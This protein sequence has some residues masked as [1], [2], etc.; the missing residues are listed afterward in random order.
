MEIRI[1][2]RSSRGFTLVELLVV[3]AI[4]GILIALLLPAIQA[5]RE[6]ARRMT[7]Q[8]NL[9]Q[10]GLGIISY[11]NTRKEYPPP[12]VPDNAPFPPYA[13]HSL[14]P[15]IAPYIE[16]A[17]L[18]KN[19]DMKQHWNSTKNLPFSQQD[20][21]IFLCP[22]APSVP[23]GGGAGGKSLTDYGPCTDL[24][25]SSVMSTLTSIG[26]LKRPRKDGGLTWA[27]GFFHIQNNYDSSYQC[28]KCKQ[29]GCPKRVTA[30]NIQDGI[31]HTMMWFEDGGRPYSYTGKTLDSGSSVSG[32]RWADN[33]NWWI[34]HN[35]CANGYQ[36]FNCNNNNEIY[37]FHS[38]G[39]NFLYGDGS[40]RFHVNTIDAETFVSLF[41]RAAGDAIEDSSAL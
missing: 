36:V 3:I 19:Y 17:H 16:I 11:E 4:I 27:V 21:G 2:N 41:T 9:R 28:P 26:A 34:E 7:C 5:T 40:V 20:I 13:K 6:T 23:R 14:Y 18:L 33:A 24:H 38:G 10:I 30:K 32:G 29:G 31:S 1:R 35:T 37:S 25:T 8:S 22:T 12:Y 39:C 15:Y